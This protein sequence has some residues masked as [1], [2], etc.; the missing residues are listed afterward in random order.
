MDEIEYLASQEGIV[1]LYNYEREQK[2][3]G[4]TLKAQGYEEGKAEGRIE[5]TKE[6]VINSLNNGLDKNLISKLTG[7][8]LSEIEEI[9]KNT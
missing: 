7:L 4:A 5:I 3:I 2:R 1:G 6:I 9:S 8:S